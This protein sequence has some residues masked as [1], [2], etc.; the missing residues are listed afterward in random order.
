MMTG[1]LFHLAQRLETTLAEG[2]LVNQGGDLGYNYTLA[3]TQISHRIKR[4]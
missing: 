4:R 2:G 3:N 1:E